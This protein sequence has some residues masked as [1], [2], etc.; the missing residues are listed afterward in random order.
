MTTLG[1]M[2]S[3]GI[4]VTQD[5]ALGLEWY[6]KAAELGY[7]GAQYNL[8]GM[9]VSG[10]VQK[11]HNTPPNH[12][13]F[14]LVNAPPTCVQPTFSSRKKIVSSSCVEARSSHNRL[15]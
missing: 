9:L 14:P 7:V 15:I 6:R 3:E 1:T 5:D 8:G 11:L 10:K 2:Y 4:E 12:P 13:F